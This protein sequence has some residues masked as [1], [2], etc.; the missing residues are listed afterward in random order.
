[1]ETNLDERIR[2]L[3]QPLWES[4]ARPYGVALDFWLMAE[5][6]VMEMVSATARL[7]NK[8]A[9]PPPPP[10]SELPDG[11]P[12]ARVREMAECMW[13]SAGRQYGVAQDFWLSAERHVLAMLRMGAFPVRDEKQAW[14]AEVASLSPSAYLERIRLM[15]YNY[16]ETAGRHYGQALDSWLQAERDML[17]MMGMATQGEGQPSAPADG[18]SPAG[19]PKGAAAA[20]LSEPQER[21]NDGAPPAAAAKG[22]AELPERTAAPS[23]TSPAKVRRSR[24]AAPKAA[25]ARSPASD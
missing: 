7:Q 16:W 17:K 24:R 4:A 25:D 3:A 11:M 19:A 23:P 12:V 10:L 14:A 22:E 18:L 20:D 2:G 6:M 1:M 13:D 21:E 15:A 8:A 9:S 5:Q